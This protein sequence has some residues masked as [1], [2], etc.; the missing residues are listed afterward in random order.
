MTRRPAPNGANLLR[1][2]ASTR[3]GAPT[4]V[5]LETGG[6]IYSTDS[7]DGDV[8]VA[9]HPW[10]VS[11]EPGGPR[12][13]AS[14]NEIVAAIRSLTAVGGRVR[15]LVGPLKV[16]LPGA[17]AAALSLAPGMLVR[18]RFEPADTRLIARS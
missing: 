18:A 11:L 3:P 5:A 6:L 8:D 14:P 16:E 15:A 2:R 1:G 10:Q 9:I 4:E 13:D 7:L 17:S 12:A